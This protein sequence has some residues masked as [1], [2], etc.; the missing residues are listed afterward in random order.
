MHTSCCGGVAGHTVAFLLYRRALIILKHLWPGLRISVH[1]I[2]GDSCLQ[3][4]QSDPIS[5][6]PKKSSVQ[7]KVLYPLITDI[8]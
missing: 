7:Q 4:H 5:Y 1:H 6:F 2:K 8:Y 3:C